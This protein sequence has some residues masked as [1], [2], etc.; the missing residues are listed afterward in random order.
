MPYIWMYQSIG[1]GWWCYKIVINLSVSLS[2][3]IREYKKALA[4]GDK[5]S[6]DQRIILGR[7]KYCWLKNLQSFY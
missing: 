7:D 4:D 6:P 3:R 5:K 2:Y 1:D